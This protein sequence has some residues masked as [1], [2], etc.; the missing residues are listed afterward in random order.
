MSFI[1]GAI[2]RSGGAVAVRTASG[3]RFPAPP[4]QAADGLHVSIGVRPE[5]YR[6]APDG[7]GVPFAVEVVEPTGAETH[8][9]GTIDS[10]EVRCVFHD[11]MAVRP[12]TILNLAVDP[13]RAHL[14]DHASGARL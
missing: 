14:F 6:I 1:D 4:T 13:N 7:G 2:D 5:D 10:T 8:L 9:H 12:G 11:R 3:I